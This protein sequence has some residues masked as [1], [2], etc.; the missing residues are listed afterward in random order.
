MPKKKRRF[1]VRRDHELSVLRAQI[2]VCIHPYVQV[3]HNP[4]STSHLRF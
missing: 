2:E 4:T 1:I 3:V